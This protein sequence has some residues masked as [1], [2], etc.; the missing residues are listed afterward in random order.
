MKPTKKDF[1]CLILCAVLFMGAIGLTVSEFIGSSPSAPPIPN[2]P[3]PVTIEIAAVGDN[4]MHMPVI[5]SGRTDTGYNFDGLYESMKKYL[6]GMDIKA[7]NQETVFINDPSR[8]SGYP[9]FGGPSAV[10]DSLVKAGFNVIQ[11]A[12]NHSYDKGTDGLNDTIAYWKTQPVTLLGVNETPEEALS[13]DKFT[14][15]GF[16]VAMLNYTYG[17]NGYVL[18]SGKEHLVNVLSDEARPAIAEQIAR[19]KSGS[20]IVVMFVHWGTEYDTSPDDYQRDWLKFFNE[21]GVDV[22]IGSHPHVIQTAEEYTGENGYKT[23]VFYSLGNFVSN[24]DSISKELGGMARVT[25]IKDENGARVAD[26]SLDPFFTH[27]SGGK[28]TVYKLTDYTDDMSR[29]HS[30]YG[31]SL[32]TEM[33]WKKYYEITGFAEGS[34]KPS[35]ESIE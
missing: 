29:T 35:P 4:L 31:G 15:D 3:Q 1:A 8:Y 7:V 10:G 25:L 2:E 23:V 20:D 21:N 27:V 18:P 14:K 11:Q 28:Y 33:I 22:I 32:T 9:S 26:Y 34:T 5:N 19:A 30:K 17:L 16:T 13:V 6:E 24:Q 12:S